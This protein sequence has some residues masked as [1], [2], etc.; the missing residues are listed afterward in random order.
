MLSL[1]NQY[2][3]LNNEAI[4]AHFADFVAANHSKSTDLWY[5]CG[6]DTPLRW[7]YPLG[8]LF[9]LHADSTQLPWHITVHYSAFPTDKLLRCPSDDTIKA[10]YTNVLKEA[11]YLKHGDGSR[12]ANL[13]LQDST[14]LWE[15]LLT[16][17][18]FFVCV[19]IMGFIFKKKRKQTK[20]RTCFCFLIFYNSKSLFKI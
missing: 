11:N 19:V 17:K 5:S 16:S 8:V 13:S 3:T 14:N 10:H 7:H 4:R 6:D 2:I 12:V 18:F 20:Q 15:G 9:D 1:R